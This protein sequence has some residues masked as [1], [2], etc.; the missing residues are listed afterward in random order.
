MAAQSEPAL[1]TLKMP[2]YTLLARQARVQGVVK[3][4]FTLLPH[5]VEATN[6]QVVS[7]P[8]DSMGAATEELKRTALDNV[9]AWRFENG[10]AVEHRYETTFEFKLDG[11]TDFV[12]FQSF[13]RV[14]I[15]AGEGP[16]IAN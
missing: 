5:S 15:V 2:R 16:V 3:V 4:A 9:K 10:D 7:A 14:T 6:V 11:A 8:P 1:L 12:S 13:H